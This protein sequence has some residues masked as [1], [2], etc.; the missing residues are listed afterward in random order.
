MKA[1]NLD[2]LK[3]ELMDWEENIMEAISQELER[4]SRR[5]GM[6]ELP[7]NPFMTEVSIYLDTLYL[8]GG[9][10]MLDTAFADTAHKSLLNFM[11]D[12]EIDSWGLLGL[13]DGLSSIDEP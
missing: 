5:V 9:N 4:I 3:G 10:V 12:A 2:E 13:L 11:S 6:M 1:K 7:E 8:E